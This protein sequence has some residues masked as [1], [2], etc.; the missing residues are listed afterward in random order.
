MAQEKPTQSS[1]IDSLWWL[2]TLPWQLFCAAVDWC[3]KRCRGFTDIFTGGPL[4]DD[5]PVPKKSTDSKRNT[6]WA[7]ATVAGVLALLLMLAWQIHGL[8]TDREAEDPSDLRLADNSTADSFGSP[9]PPTQIGNPKA[10]HKTDDGFPP[11]NPPKQADDNPGGNS[12]PPVHLAGGPKPEKGPDFGFDV[13]P[14]KKKDDPPQNNN[15]PPSFNFNDDKPKKDDNPIVDNKEPKVTFPGFGSPEPKKTEPDKKT[16]NKAGKDQPMFPGFGDPKRNDEPKNVTPPN[17]AK[18]DDGFPSF[19]PEN[20]EPKTA[21]PPDI[22]RKK[23]DGFPDF[24]AGKTEPKKTE[25]P[26]KVADNKKIT[27]P[28]F[29]PEKKQPATPVLPIGTEPKTVDRGEQPLSLEIVRISQPSRD[30]FSNFL[31]TSLLTKDAAVAKL[32]VAIPE[33]ST[34]WKAVR[35]AGDSGTILPVRYS[36]AATGSPATSGATSISVGASAGL[37]WTVGRP[38]LNYQIV[39]LQSGDVG[40]AVAIRLLVTNTG[41]A[42]LTDIAVHLDLPAELRYRVG[43]RLEHK[44]DRLAPGK[45]HVARLTP[46]AIKAGVARITGRVIAGEQTVT[47]EQSVTIGSKTASGS[48]LRTSLSRRRRTGCC[49]NAGS[50]Y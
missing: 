25:P 34:G 33:E 18:K 2:V 1:W 47:A 36:A 27:V 26:P 39:V 19:G 6:A 17:V 7:F 5:K 22:V 16:V 48:F 38:K 29:G 50:R 31:V 10:P 14:P 49:G 4:P 37:T 20:K 28:A 41:D 3:V 32:D 21:T 46:T 23:D 15:D 35:W 44:I 30:D 40:D 8:M 43:R 42:T 12:E 45:T 11:F 9:L 13:D 24:G